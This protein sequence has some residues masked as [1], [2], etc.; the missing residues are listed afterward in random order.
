MLRLVRTRIGPLADRKLSPGQWRELSPSEVR[1]LERSASPPES[2]FG[3]GSGG[4]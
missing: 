2:E 4:R 1:E 3:G